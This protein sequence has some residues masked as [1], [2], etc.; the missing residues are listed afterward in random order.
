MKNILSLLL[1]IT[2]VAAKAQTPFLDRLITVETGI[3][4]TITFDNANI[5]IQSSNDKSVKLKAGT[6]FVL[7]SKKMIKSDDK[8]KL[9]TI[10]IRILEEGET[11]EDYDVEGTVGYI[12]PSSTSLGDYADYNREVI[13]MPGSRGPIE[14]EDGYERN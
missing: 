9:Y 4:G 3:E 14:D 8:L 12:Y 7:L 1:L 10:K 11:E 5:Q 2:C 6:R 13:A